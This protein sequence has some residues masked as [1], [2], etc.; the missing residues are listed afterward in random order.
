MALP[1]RFF[2]YSMSIGA[3]RLPPHAG[4]D[5]ATSFAGVVQGRLIAARQ[6]LHQAVKI[7]IALVEGFH[8]HALVLA[9]GA[10]VERSPL[11]RP[12]ALR[13]RSR[14][15]L[16]QDPNRPDL[17]GDHPPLKVVQ[18][19]NAAIIFCGQL[20]RRRIPVKPVVNVGRK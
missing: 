14:S 10:E 8:R 13:G 18:K 11:S 12:R 20:K 1:E 19:L 5:E 16:F 2:S 7:F 9:M 4:D 17:G 15:H 3:R 6:H